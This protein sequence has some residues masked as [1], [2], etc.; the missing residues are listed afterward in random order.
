MSLISHSDRI[1]VSG[2]LGM[3]GSA[4]IRALR[5]KGYQNLLTVD[6]AELD[7][8]DSAAV[9]RWISSNQPNVVVIAAG[10]VG[11][12]SANCNYPAKF[13]LENLKIQLN[14][15]ENSFLSGVRR[16]LFLGSS[17]MYPKLTN[18]PIKEEAL[19]SSKLELTNESYA[20]AKITG[21][22]ICEALRK[23]YNFDAIGLI[24]TNLYGP[25]DNYHKTDS[26]VIPG[27][28]RRFHE[29]KNAGLPDVKCW[30]SGKPLRE[31]LYSDDFGFACLFALENWD[32]S[33]KYA[34][35]DLVGQQLN[36]LNVGTEEEISINQLAKLIA[37]KVGYSGNIIWD[38][39]QPDGMLR[40]KLD[41]TRFN[42]LGWES[43]TSL[44][45]G[46]TKTIDL[47]LEKI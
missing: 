33:S 30:G 13:I 36:Y 28:I 41:L 42:S 23:Q 3:A 17:C 38:L 32:P 37:K 10:K 14:L 7:L 27:L 40:K 45:N 35:K 46:L 20:I 34:P 21:L 16:L 11:G 2:H 12:I 5:S 47:F 18:Q 39:N 26:H 15:I 25:G 9:K 29:A 44:E 19:M 43:T 24:P 31:F 6:R 4:I 1:Y 22:K 8:L